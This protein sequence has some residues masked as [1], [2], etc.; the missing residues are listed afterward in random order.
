LSR[1]CIEELWAAHQE[2]IRF[3]VPLG[4]REW[5]LNLGIGIG[6]DRVTELDW[7]DETWLDQTGGKTALDREQMLRVICTPAQH[8]SGELNFFTS[9][10]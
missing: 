7:W 2:Y 10:D 9:S 6:E 5:F 4:D 3:L 1:P 8:G